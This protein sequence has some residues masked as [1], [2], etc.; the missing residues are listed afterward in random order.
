MPAVTCTWRT[1]AEVPQ[2][3][4]RRP[5]T[6]CSCLITLHSASHVSETPHSASHAS[7]TLP[8]SLSATQTSRAHQISP[9]FDTT[10]QR[11]PNQ[12]F[13]P[14]EPSLDCLQMQLH[15]PHIVCLATATI[16]LA[17]QLSS[18][19]LDSALNKTVKTTTALSFLV[20]GC[21]FRSQ[22]HHAQGQARLGGW[23]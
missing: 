4:H 3:R 9:W 20:L 8:I 15:A 11:C 5:S 17:P 14:S 23:H 22:S 21:I 12:R 6:N 16:V 10:G 19:F 13:R 18:L 1:E 2:D 7:Q